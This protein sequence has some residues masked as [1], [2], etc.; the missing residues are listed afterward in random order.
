[1]GKR[2]RGRGGSTCVWCKGERG[3]VEEWVRDPQDFW[4]LLKMRRNGTD[5]A[6]LSFFFPKLPL[7]LQLFH[8]LFGEK[9]ILQVLVH[10]YFYFSS[11][12]YR[13]IFPF[14]LSLLFQ[15]H[16]LAIISPICLSFLHF[17]MR[18]KWY[19]VVNPN[20]SYFYYHSLLSFSSISLISLRLNNLKFY[21][22]SYHFPSIHLLSLSHKP[23]KALRE[24]Q[25]ST[26]LTKN[27]SVLPLMWNK[28]TSVMSAMLIN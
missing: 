5:H 6:L 10:S 8:F 22:F 12:S 20:L 3:E 17:S 11:I 15:S 21:S 7:L 25:G 13:H 9:C 19:W 14:Y 28:E 1:M 4:D 26:T 16:H 23:N 24:S 18:W 27:T 2:V